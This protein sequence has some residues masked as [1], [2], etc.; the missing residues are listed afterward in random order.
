LEPFGSKE[1]WCST[2][3]ERNNLDIFALSRAST[4]T[5]N[6]NITIGKPSHPTYIAR[7][8][9]KQQEKKTTGEEPLQKNGSRNP[10]RS[11]Y[12][13]A[14]VLEVVP[15][16]TLGALIGFGGLKKSKEKR[17]KTE[18]KTKNVKRKCLSKP[19]SLTN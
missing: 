19:K 4:L 5:H 2:S 9:Q 6:N 10:S 7:V 15:I 12:I 18:K 17:A 13:I 14:T 16:L 3:Q 1:S 11:I 8:R